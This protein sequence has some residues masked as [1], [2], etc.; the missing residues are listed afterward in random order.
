MHPN[1]LTM[2]S[3]HIFYFSYIHPAPKG[4][5]LDLWAHA[6]ELSTLNSQFAVRPLLTVFH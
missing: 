5:V 4:D 6:D 1:Q 2:A 3:D